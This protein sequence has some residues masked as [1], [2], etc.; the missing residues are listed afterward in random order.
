MRRRTAD[1]G[2]FTEALLEGVDTRCESGLAAASPSSAPRAP[3]HRPR[4]HRDLRARAT[5]SARVIGVTGTNGKTTVTALAGEMRAR[6]GVRLRSRGQHRPAGARR[7]RRRE[8][9]AR[10]RRCRC[11]S[12]PASSSRPPRRSPHA[13]ACSISPRTTSTATTGSADYAAAK[14]RIFSGTARRCSTATTARR[15]PWRAPAARDRPSALGAPGGERGGI[16]D[17]RPRDTRCAAR[18]ELLGVDELP[19][20][21]LHNAANALAA[22]ALCSALGLPDA[23]RRGARAS[24]PAAPAGAGGRRGRRRWYDDSKG[25]NVGAT[26]AALRASTRAGGADRRRRRQGTG[27]LAARAGRWRRCARRWC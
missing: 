23:A 16:S 11:S 6:R 7:A 10:R 15:W 2:P 13:A 12:S 18:G 22:H 14:A 17:A 19:V 25:T 24:G 20:P 3:R 4:R 9:R 27:F 8:R 26:V 5:R 21:G 1:L